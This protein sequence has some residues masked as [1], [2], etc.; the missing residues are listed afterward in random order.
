MSNQ[1]IYTNKEASE[2]LRISE[3]TLWRERKAGKISFR[4]VASKVVFL[5]EDLE[6]YLDQNKREAFA[7]K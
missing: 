3:I 6:K 5:Q 1:K 7:V 4:R 2:Y